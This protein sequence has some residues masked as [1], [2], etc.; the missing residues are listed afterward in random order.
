MTQIAILNGMFS[1]SKAD[2]RS[3]Y[4]VNLEP[5]PKKTGISNGYLRTAP[6]FVEICTVPDGKD[7]GGITW[8]G[9]AYRVNGPSLYQIN[10]DGTYK[11][12]GTIADDGKRVTMVY[13]F[14]KL[15]IAS[16]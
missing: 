16:S 11:K 1:D 12:L 7:R 10:E 6:G 8:Q 3:S 9:V 15:A 2:F 14:D 4:P 5:V 13:S